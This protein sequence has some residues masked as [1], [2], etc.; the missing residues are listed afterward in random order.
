MANHPRW[1]L[2][3][4]LE[5]ITVIDLAK[6]MR[7]LE[8]SFTGTRRQNSCDVFAMRALEDEER[9]DDLHDKKAHNRFQSKF[10]DPNQPSYLAMLLKGTP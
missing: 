7:I 4:T 6:L 5:F 1:R 2:I 10:T 9:L 8:Q 3:S